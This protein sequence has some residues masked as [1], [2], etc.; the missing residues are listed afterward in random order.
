MNRYD[1]GDPFLEHLFFEGREIHCWERLGAHLL[2]EGG[3]RF[4]LWAPRA[5]QV[6]L[7]GDFNDWD[8]EGTELFREGDKEFFTVTLGE[9]KEGDRYRYRIIT[10]RGEECYKSDPMAFYSEK[11]PGTASVVTSLPKVAGCQRHSYEEPMAIYEVNLSSWTRHKDGGYCSYREL[12]DTLLPYVSEMGYTHLELMPIAEH[13]YD[14]SWGY[15]ITGYFSPTARFGTPED[16]AYF[17]NKA[18]DLGLKVLLDWVPHHFVSDSHGLREFD[19]FPLYEYEGDWGYNPLWGTCNFNLGKPAVRSFLLSNALYWLKVYG[20]DG[21]RVDAVAYILSRRGSYEAFGSQDPS[22]AFPDGVAFLK[23]LTETVRREVPGAVLIAEDSSAYP[24]VTTPVDQGGL[25]FHYKWNM[26]WMHDT[27][28]YMTRDPLDRKYH[29]RELTFP[30]VYG[31]REHY[32]LPLSHDEAVHGK[33]SLLDKMPGSPEDKALQLKLLYLY[34]Y[35]QPG[36]KLL[37]M[38][39]ELGQWIE[40]NEWRELDWMLLKYPYHQNIKRFLQALNELY[41]A[42]KALHREG[43]WE[44]FRWVEHE[45]HQESILIFERIYKKDRLLCLFNFTPVSRK[46]YPVGVMEKGE[47]RELINTHGPREVLYETAE[48]F[49]IHGREQYIRVDLEG[50]MGLVIKH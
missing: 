46:G 31:F 23:D 35:T 37:F 1:P 42:E 39:G 24:D 15:Q 13:P 26:G 12:A 20:F 49:S 14:G 19:G 45:N 50:F 36:K 10:G 25:G 18:H 29:Q 30:M 9:A 48:D 4:I 32:V 34:Q 47:Y 11:P 40:W 8:R 27:L 21:L 44:S 33:K 41:K 17:L 16:L 22:E 5:R 28:S 3:V 2:P 38:G 7:L 6:F 43:G